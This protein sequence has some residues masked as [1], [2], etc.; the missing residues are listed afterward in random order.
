[1]QFIEQNLSDKYHKEKIS[2]FPYPLSQKLQK[3]LD[4]YSP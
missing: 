2:N 4:K 1:M 3:Y